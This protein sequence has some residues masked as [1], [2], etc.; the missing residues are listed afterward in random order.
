MATNPLVGIFRVKEL[1]ERVIFTML[2]LVSLPKES[3]DEL[4]GAFAHLTSA[5]YKL[6]VTRTAAGRT[7][8][9]WS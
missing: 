3:L 2:M 1:R 4:D 8:G 5:G 9:G 7:R 6:T